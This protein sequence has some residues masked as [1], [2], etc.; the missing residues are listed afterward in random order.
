G[1]LLIGSGL[2][3]LNVDLQPTGFLRTITLGGGTALLLLVLVNFE[4]Q[5]RILAPKWLVHLGATS[6]SLYL[7]HLLIIYGFGWAWYS[8]A[9]L[10]LRPLAPILAVFLAV[11]W[12]W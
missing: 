9:P 8:K 5:Q 11:V 12:A 7:W 2:F 4:R 3:L 1:F 10:P 6:Y